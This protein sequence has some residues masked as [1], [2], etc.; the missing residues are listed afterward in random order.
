[1]KK[2][3]WLL[4]NDKREL[5]EAQRRVNAKGGLRAFC[6]LS[7]EAVEAAI[8]R[9]QEYVNMEQSEYENMPSLVILDYKS[10]V[11]EQFRTLKLLQN[12]VEYAGVPVFFM[13]DEKSDSLDEECYQRGATVVLR[14]PFSDASI[15]RIERT[16]W[17]HENT[18]NYEKL[19]KTQA[20]EL[21]TAKEIKR[22]NEQL[23]SR[24][25]LLHQIFGRYFSDE[26][27][28]VILDNPEGA[29]IGGVKREVTVLF[30]DLRGFTAMSGSLEPDVVTDILNHFLGTMTEVIISYGGTA[31]EFIGDAILVVFGAPFEIE[32]SAQA[33]ITAAI[34]MQN[35]MK[36]VN[37]YNELQGYPLIEM[38]IGV[39]K[40]QVFVGNIGSERMMRYNVIGKAVNLC[41]RIEGLS[42]GGQVLVSNDTVISAACPVKVD[43]S[44][45]M[46]MKGVLESV[47]VSEVV[48]IDG[49]K[50][51][52]L[53]YEIPDKLVKLSENITLSL[54]PI[55]DKQISDST[56][57]AKLLMLSM[58]K[59][60]ITL[61]HGENKDLT[62]D[63]DGLEL[64]TNVAV[65]ARDDI[66]A[67][68]FANVYAKV[69]K[70]DGDI[71]T[72]HFTYVTRG[73]SNFYKRLLAKEYV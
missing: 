31:I 6:M 26:V 48:A 20:N 32:N 36:L 29:A 27:V 9:Q 72:I 59:A 55:E 23:K 43:H 44:F 39:H 64:F 69:V 41:S 42:V 34:D 61:V 33:G 65:T 57:E 58:K 10:E 47:G 49:S 25:Q 63:Y 56:I 11:L 1:M 38:G 19:L 73:F 24:N 8:C 67:E 12:K 46:N 35:H 15:L 50:S 54:A 22:L 4:N 71:I 16:A 17:Q 60:Q 45:N 68:E 53:E 14:K 21:K 13:V 52:K 62:K 5:I 37:E 3:I 70:R 51:I 2:N 66:G 7:Y 30:A 28:E 18:K 40:G